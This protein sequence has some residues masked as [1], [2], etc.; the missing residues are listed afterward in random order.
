MSSLSSHA[1]GAAVFA[2]VPLLPK[3]KIQSD[4]IQRPSQAG[5]K[6]RAGAV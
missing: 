2:F 1:L 3:G 5:A 6:V 4:V